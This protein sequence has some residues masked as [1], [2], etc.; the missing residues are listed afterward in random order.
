LA[1]LGA[2]GG[3]ELSQVS[4]RIIALAGQAE[5]AILEEDHAAAADLI[6]SIAETVFAVEVFEPK[7]NLA[8]WNDVLRH[9][10]GGLALSEVP[11]DRVEV[12]QFIEDDVIYR[13]VWGMEAAK[14]Y[15][16]AQSNADADTLSGS[17]VAAIE[18][19]TFNRAVS[20]L[21]RTGFD[22]R[23]AAISAV[24]STGATFDSADGMRQWIDDLDPAY[25]LDPEWPTPESRS[26]WEVFVNPSR[27]RR[28]RQWSQQTQDVQE[29]TWYGT[30]PEPDTWLRITD[31]T[32]GKINIWSTG[33]DLLGEA[34]ILLDQERQGILRARRH[35]A[36]T[37]IRL[38]Y[39]GPKDL[40][41]RPPTR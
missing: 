30:P 33:F 21:I 29:V 28:A 31:A 1:G 38:R 19:G 10:V 39:R 4:G 37:G 3:S 9:W 34:A 35:R 24:T 22:H 15:E 7:T 41:P 6:V 2:E 26:A 5:T 20:I 18:T 16:A 27:T 11:G 23:L 17:A 14:V 8:N 32:P 36:G 25:G 40:L 12:A 13:L